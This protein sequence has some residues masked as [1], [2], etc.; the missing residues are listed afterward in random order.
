MRQDDLPERAPYRVCVPIPLWIIDQVLPTLRDTELRVLMIVL[1]Q[2][3]N[4]ERDWLSSRQLH[5]RTGR[6]SAAV[7]G[8]IDTLVRRGLITV[9]A[10]SGSILDMPSERRRCRHRLWFQRGPAIT[11]SSLGPG[12]G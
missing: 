3:A 10:Q 11:S 7:S 4:K 9:T 5:Q 1:R 6:S 2:T 8:A 12:R